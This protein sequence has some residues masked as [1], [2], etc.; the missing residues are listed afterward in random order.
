MLRMN[1][2]AG[3]AGALRSK[4]VCSVNTTVK[5][6][7]AFLRRVFLALV[8]VTTVTGGLAAF[9]TVQAMNAGGGKACLF[10]CE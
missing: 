9:T 6:D 7:A 4:G 8:F 2:A 5:A 3:A 10:Y 1:Q